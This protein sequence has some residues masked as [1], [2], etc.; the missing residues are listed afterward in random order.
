MQMQL[1]LNESKRLFKIAL[2]ANANNGDLYYKY[3][4]VLLKE[5]NAWFGYI[6][7]SV[8]PETNEPWYRYTG[9]NWLG[10]QITDE[11]LLQMRYPK[12]Y[13]QFDIRDVDYIPI[14][15]QSGLNQAILDA[16]HYFY[17]TRVFQFPSYSPLTFK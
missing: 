12:R 16:I 1:Q 9:E 4:S 8:D 17:Q 5:T 3:R 2:E 7:E 11:G 15:H 13:D 6:E 10:N 14:E